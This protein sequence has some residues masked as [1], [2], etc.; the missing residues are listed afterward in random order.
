MPELATPAE[1]AE[2]LALLKAK[3]PADVYGAIRR[4]VT[5]DTRPP[6][7]PRHDPPDMRVFM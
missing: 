6:R 3:L 1:Q 4:F 7:S 5:G 2:Y